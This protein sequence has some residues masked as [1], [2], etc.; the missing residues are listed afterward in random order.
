[1]KD[2]WDRLEAWGKKSGA[3]SLSLRDG[4][5]EKQIVAAEKKMKLQFSKDLRESFLVHD[6][7]EEREGEED[8][9]AFFWWMPGCS[10]LRSLDDVVDRWVEEQ[11]MDDGQDEE[12]KEPD[13]S[14]NKRLKAALHHPK[15]IP[16]AGNHFWDGDNTYIDLAPGSKGSVGQLITFT[17][18]C[19][20]AVLGTSLRASLERYVQMLESG[21]LVWNPESGILQ[22][23]KKE[24]DGNTSEIF[25]RMK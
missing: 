3:G 7:Q 16:I 9:G 10:R 15:R 5:T 12:D 13:A 11:D 6:G 23:G 19:D 1:M 22:K 25:A 20:L 24:W 4:V 8:G 18:E 2:V 14:G 17:T 21:K